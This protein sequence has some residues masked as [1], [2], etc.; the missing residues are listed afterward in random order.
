MSVLKALD[1]ANC[2]IVEF[3][4]TDIQ[5]LEP[6]DRVNRWFDLMRFVYPRLKE[7]DGAPSLPSPPADGSQP[8]APLP[9]SKEARLGLI[10]G[11]IPRQPAA[12]G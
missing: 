1:V 2:P 7:V 3:L 11:Q 5:C 8:S 10:H 6:H 4:I 9:S 12:S